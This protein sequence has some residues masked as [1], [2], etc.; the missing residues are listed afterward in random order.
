MAYFAARARPTRLAAGQPAAD[1]TPLAGADA[2]A[3][4]VPSAPGAWGGPGTGTEP[5][6]AD[7]VADYQLEAVLD[8]VRH[9]VDGKERLTWRNR[10]DRAVG[11][12][13]FHLYLNAFEGPGS[14]FLTEK[15]RYGG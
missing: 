11:S 15:A 7:R 5:T 4:G 10:S 2:G 1:D 14:T 6:L 8:P 12:L 9:T 13:Y 3:V